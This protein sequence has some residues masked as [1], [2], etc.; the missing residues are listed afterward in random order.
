MFVIFICIPL[1][2]LNL[3]C[4]PLERIQTSRKFNRK[5]KAFYEGIKKTSK[6][7][8]AYFLIFYLRR[9]NFCVIAFYL[10]PLTIVKI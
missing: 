4:T 3:M 9:V 5:W 6:G 7:T 8:L 10:L 2:L 1:G